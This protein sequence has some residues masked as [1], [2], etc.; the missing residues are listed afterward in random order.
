MMLE[1]KAYDLVRSWRRGDINGN[2]F[3][4]RLEM[5]GVTETFC[6]S[7]A[8]ERDAEYLK[9]VIREAAILS[10]TAT[11][12]TCCFILKGADLRV[13]ENRESQRHSMVYV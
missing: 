13:T 3:D 9:E 8:R 11:I 2:Q 4:Y 6:Y 7:V 12:I 10:L 5:L 1:E